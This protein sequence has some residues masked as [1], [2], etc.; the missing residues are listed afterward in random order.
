MD[1]FAAHELQL[2]TAAAAAMVAT[3]QQR[4]ATALAAAT[5]S[6]RSRR[7]GELE[8]DHAAEVLRLR[9]SAL[10]SEAAAL[11]LER[12]RVEAAVQEE[13]EALRAATRA[14]RA[15]QQVRTRGCVDTCT[16]GMRPHETRA[17]CEGRAGAGPRPQTA[18]RRGR[19]IPRARGCCEFR[20]SGRGKLWPWRKQAY[21][22]PL[23][24]PPPVPRM[25]ALGAPPRMAMLLPG[26]LCPLHFGVPG[27][28][29]SRGVAV[30]R[31]GNGASWAGECVRSAHCVVQ[32]T[33]MRLRSAHRQWP[34]ASS[35]PLAPNPAP[36]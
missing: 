8:A 9:E 21:R 3:A 6:E 14:L 32:Q 5:A 1:D 30:G 33:G 15:T 11:Y 12:R 26:L 23:P 18:V 34:A 10:E 27:A 25:Q 7:L 16:A 28:G 20:P 36:V 31:D 24:G 17:A 35:A 2:T 19:A 22:P 13:A 29:A 4:A